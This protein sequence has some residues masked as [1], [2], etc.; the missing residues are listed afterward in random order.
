MVNLTEDSE[1]A[2]DFSWEDLLH[3]LR[4]EL[5]EYGGL[6]GLLSNQ[7]ESILNR[8][9]EG[10]VSLELEYSPDPSKIV[11]WVEEAYSSTAEMMAQVGLRD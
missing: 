11:E 5:G 3:L 9:L 4:E 2:A 7:Q 10:S 8:E 6:M 1:V